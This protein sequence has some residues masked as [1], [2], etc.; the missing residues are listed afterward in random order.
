MISLVLKTPSETEE[1]IDMCLLS[2][3]LGNKKQED[4]FNIIP[5]T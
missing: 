2:L 1:V 5:D 3:A 4:L